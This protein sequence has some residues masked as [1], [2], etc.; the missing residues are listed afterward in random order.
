MIKTQNPKRFS[1]EILD[2]EIVSDFVLRISNFSIGVFRCLTLVSFTSILASWM[3]I[4]AVDYGTKRIGM[5]TGDDSG[6]VIRAV[7]TL[8]SRGVKRDAHQIREWARNLGAQRIIVGLPLEM[9]GAQGTSAQ[10][11]RKLAAQ[12]QKVASLPIILWDERLTSKAAD[13]WMRAHGLKRAQ[14]KALRDQMAACLILE[15]YVSHHGR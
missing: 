15:D 14:R 12:L 7:T 2:V 13:E 8:H 6:L 9:S 3:R 1:I 4:L 5:A 10:R 11:A